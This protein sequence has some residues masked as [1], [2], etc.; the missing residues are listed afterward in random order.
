MEGN[1]NLS[2]NGFSTKF[3]FLYFCYFSFSEMKIYF[4]KI[5]CLSNLILENVK[6][7][8]PVCLK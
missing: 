8:Y 2:M 5:K 6:C 4:P 7:I 1:K 3:L